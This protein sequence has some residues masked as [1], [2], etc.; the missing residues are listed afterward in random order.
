MHA[1]Q[2]SS[3]QVI[4]PAQ[5]CPRSVHVLVE[6]AIV[7]QQMAKASEHFEAPGFQVGMWI[8]SVRC[9]MHSPASSRPK[10]PRI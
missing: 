5:L 9:S 7:S 10:R 1:W 6:R 3:G 4:D 2:F 8:K